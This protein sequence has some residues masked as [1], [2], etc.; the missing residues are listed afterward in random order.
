VLLDPELMESLAAA[1]LERS[2][3]FCWDSCARRTLE[4]LEEVARNRGRQVV[5]ARDGA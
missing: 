2:K 3:T 5:A 4:I 1:G